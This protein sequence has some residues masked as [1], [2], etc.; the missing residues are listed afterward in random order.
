MSVEQSAELKAKIASVREGDEVDVTYGATRM[1]FVAQRVDRDGDWVPTNG[2]PPYVFTREI[3]AVHSAQRPEMP[4]PDVYERAIDRDGRVWFRSTDG[5]TTEV[6]WFDSW[7]ELV[8]VRGPMR[9]F[10]RDLIGTPL[11]GGV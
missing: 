5:W 2:L 3:A 6:R 4:E 9:P 8:R 10:S 7:S 1:Q 11:E